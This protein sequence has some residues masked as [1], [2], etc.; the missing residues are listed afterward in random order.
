MATASPITWH[1]SKSKLA[2]RIV[3]HFPVYRTYCEPFG[4]S[5][6]VLLAK[7]PSRVEIFNDR[8]EELTNLFRVLR[9]PGSFAKLRRAV[10]NTLYARAEFELSKQKPDDPVE[11]ARRFIVR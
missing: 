10:Q 11:A 9:D 4:G 8:N 7:T 2:P 1:G 5:A 6:S 3:R